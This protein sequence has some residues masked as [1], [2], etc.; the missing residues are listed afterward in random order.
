MKA[1]TIVMLILALVVLFATMTSC[2][3]K[4]GQLMKTPLE[5]VVVI[6][7][8]ERIPVSKT[9]DGAMYRTKVNRIE[10]GVVTF[11]YLYQAYEKNDTI[12]HRFVNE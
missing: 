6:D 12:L 11:I 5:K 3:S 2:E 7:I 9:A 10:K 8:A 4:S 1:T